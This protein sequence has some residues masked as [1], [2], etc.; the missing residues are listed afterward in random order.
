TTT[1]PSYRLYEPNPHGI[2]RAV[3]LALRLAALR[4][5]PNAEKR[6]AVILTN[7]N[8]KA[9]RIGAAVGLDTPASVLRILEAMREAGYQ[10]G[11]LPESGDALLHSLIDR[12]SYDREVLTATQL[13]EMPL[14]VAADVE[15]RWLDAL[16]DGRRAEM[17]GRW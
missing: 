1:D 17:I 12:G 15:A 8:A 2:E 5:K 6:I 10:V 13:E 3:G 11:D 9:S 16:P 4:R 7:A 14:H